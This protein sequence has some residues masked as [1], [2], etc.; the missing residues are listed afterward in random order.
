MRELTPGVLMVGIRLP[1]V[2]PVRL[3]C[4]VDVPQRV[5]HG[6]RFDFVL[7]A[8]GGRTEGAETPDE[9]RTDT[10]I[11]H[12]GEPVLPEI[13]VAR[14]FFGRNDGEDRTISRT[15][16]QRNAHGCSCLAGLT[17][18][19]GNAAE[20]DETAF[21][22]IDAEHPQ[23]PRKSFGGD[24]DIRP[25]PAK[26]HAIFDIDVVRTIDSRDR[27]ADLTVYAEHHDGAGRRGD[28]HG[29]ENQAARRILGVDPDSR[30]IRVVGELS[31]RIFRFNLECLRQRRRSRRRLCRILVRCRR[32][33]AGIRTRRS[34]QPAQSARTGRAFGAPRLSEPELQS[35]LNDARA[36]A[37]PRDLAE[38][39]AR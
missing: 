12:V 13:T 25:P 18:Q 23:L 26:L 4:V 19:N 17:L 10:A 37:R 1:F 8:D 14:P 2:D 39:R 5:V 15:P 35:E 21:R 31:R 3:V 22:G 27:L 32:A 34:G 9:R 29:A 36:A 38:V 20:I 16:V 24:G 33:C 11:A 28:L 6:D 7:F 30:I